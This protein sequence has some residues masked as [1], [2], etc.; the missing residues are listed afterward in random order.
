[1]YL[2][3]RIFQ[4]QRGE[5]VQNQP[6]PMVSTPIN[7]QA[8]GALLLLLAR[9]LAPLITP[10]RAVVYGTPVRLQ[11]GI[12]CHRDLDHRLLATFIG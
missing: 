6:Q 2:D 3:D 1:L 5:H 4:R 7:V 10:S 11:A 9:E 12:A 8:L